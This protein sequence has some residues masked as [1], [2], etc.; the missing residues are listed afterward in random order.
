MFAF[1]RPRHRRAHHSHE[2]VRVPRTCASP[3][4]MLRRP[5]PCSSRFFHGSGTCLCW[6]AGLPSR[7]RSK[8]RLG[9]CAAAP[10]LRRRGVPRECVGVRA[11]ARACVRACAR[12]C[13][14]LRL[15]VV[16]AERDAR[17]APL[18]I[19]ITGEIKFR[20]CGKGASPA[21]A[22]AASSHSSPPPAMPPGSL[23]HGCMPPPGPAPLPP[24]QGHE[25]GWAGWCWGGH[26]R[27]QGGRGEADRGPAG[28][29]GV[30]ARL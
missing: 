19:K 12:A 14:C 17:S 24:H 23:H 11:C 2:H 16:M 4:H 20:P 27:G 26:R 21:S 18:E 22:H 28:V 5:P 6:H 15:C 13:V 10:A 29:V 7:S 25:S 1:R 9:R 8:T 3:S 30:E